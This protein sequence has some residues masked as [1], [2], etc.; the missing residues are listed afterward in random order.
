MF[1][2]IESIDYGHATEFCGKFY[3]MLNVLKEQMK[4]GK[5]TDTPDYITRN[6]MYFNES[7]EW[8]LLDAGF[9]KA[10]ECGRPIDV[11]YMKIF[12]RKWLQSVMKLDYDIVLGEIERNF[13]TLVKT[14][15][16]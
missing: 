2:G 10:F 6:V 9:P 5:C 16:N 3:I 13:F 15:T 14:H 4:Q 12:I 1:N 7:P 8:S 11:R